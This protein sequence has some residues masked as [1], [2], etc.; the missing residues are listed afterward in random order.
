MS[1][2]RVNKI[3]NLN[4]DGPVEFSQGAELP[5]GQ[6][7]DGEVVI[8]SSG[9]VTSTSLSVNGNM[10]LSGVIT[11]TTFVG[12]GIGLTGVPGTPNGKGIA[13]TLIA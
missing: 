11:A 6:V 9:I 7:I 12:S 3:V 10:N 1:S 8:N 4:D 13:F 5:A 2:L